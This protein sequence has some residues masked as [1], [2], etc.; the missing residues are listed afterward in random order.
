MGQPE[1]ERSWTL[2]FDA[3]HRQDIIVFPRAG[4]ILEA[5]AYLMRLLRNTAEA[6]LATMDQPADSEKWLAASGTGLRH[7]GEEL[8]YR[9][10]YAHQPY[11]RPLSF[12]ASE[13]ISICEVQMNA[14]EDH[15]SLL[16]TDLQ[17]LKRH[18]QIIQ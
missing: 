15:L 1:D 9:S 4:L 17:Y 12:E 18:V 16:Q 11:S 14:L 3:I 7:A 2:N 6:I 8:G 5:Q 10:T 13:L